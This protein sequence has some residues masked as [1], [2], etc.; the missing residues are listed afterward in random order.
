MSHGSLRL[1][2]AFDKELISDALDNLTRRV[3]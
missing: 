1:K 3:M 2:L